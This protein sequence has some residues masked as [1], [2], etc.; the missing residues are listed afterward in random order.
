MTKTEVLNLEGIRAS[1]ERDS[2]LWTPGDVGHISETALVLEFRREAQVA[3]PLASMREVVLAGGGL[4][5]PFHVSARVVGRTEFES[6]SR[7][8]FHMLSEE[9]SALVGMI[10]RR[11][12]ER[13]KPSD[14]EPIR[15]QLLFDKVGV[16]EQVVLVSARDISITGIG[17]L[18][19]EEIE[20]E[21]Y[22]T[23]TVGLRIQLSTHDQ[24]FNLTARVRNRSLLGREIVYGLMFEGP[25]RADLA[26]AEELIQA[27]GKAR[28]LQI[29]AARKLPRR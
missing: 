26:A 2:G 28:A 6:K 19:D 20:A 24:F 29:R 23:D 11:M 14:D 8:E 27:Y 9:G 17:V 25:S 4:S 7:Y 3:L 1:L 5:S 21:L 18:A 16:G 13:I 12:A 22:G 15:V 10:N